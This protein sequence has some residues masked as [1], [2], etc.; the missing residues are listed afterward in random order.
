MLHPDARPAVVFDGVTD[1]SIAILTTAG[2]MAYPFSPFGI[3]VGP[4]Y[5]FN[6]YHLMPVAN[7]LE[8]FPVRFEEIR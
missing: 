7:P 3:P 6:V 2:N 5:R 4:A 8:C 1:A